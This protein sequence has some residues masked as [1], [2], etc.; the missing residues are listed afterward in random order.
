MYVI[1]SF[2]CHAKINIIN[3]AVTYIVAEHVENVHT[4][5]CQIDK[6]SRLP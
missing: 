3:F 6:K 1:W 2:G 4:V 5:D